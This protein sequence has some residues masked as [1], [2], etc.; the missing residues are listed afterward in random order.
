VFNLIIA[1]IV[2]LIT[3]KKNENIEKE[4]D[5]SKRLLKQE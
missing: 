3:Y 4:F 1:V 5:E 2:S